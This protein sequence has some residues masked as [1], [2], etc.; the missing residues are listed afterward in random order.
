MKRVPQFDGEPLTDREA[1]LARVAFIRGAQHA[2][3]YRTYADAEVEATANAL[4][5]MPKMT[6]PRVVRDTRHSAGE[7]KVDVSPYHTKE[8]PDM[9]LWW[10]PRP[11]ED[12]DVLRTVEHL[13]ADRVALWADLFARPTEEVDAE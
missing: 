11:S 3:R 7:W 1:R 4:Y 10:R 13:G 9:V 6:R 5:Q 2:T 12:W 8:S